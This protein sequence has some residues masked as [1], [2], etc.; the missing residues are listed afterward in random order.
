M[1]DQIIEKVQ[2][3]NKWLHAKNYRTWIFVFVEFVALLG[4]VTLGTLAVA[5]A[6]QPILFYKEIGDYR[7]TGKLLDTIMDTLSAEAGIVLF[8]L[9]FQ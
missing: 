4:L 9:L 7:R 5:L 1:I 2:A 3:F 8:F 6:V